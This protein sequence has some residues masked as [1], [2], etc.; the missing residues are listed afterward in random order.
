MSYLQELHEAHKARLARM[1]GKP[2]KP[3]RQVMHDRAVQ[4]TPDIASP[5]P[6]PIPHFRP[7]RQA[8][9]PIPESVQRSFII[10]RKIARVTAAAFGVQ[11]DEILAHDRRSH[12]CLARQVAVF[13][14]RKHTTISWNKIGILFGGYDTSSLRHSRSKV[15]LMVATDEKTMAIVAGI[16]R[17]LASAL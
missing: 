8:W 9:A 3:E 16:E 15:R 6:D 11:L 2:R 1:G 10:A 5:T 12:I 13:L 7:H 14:V 17:D 4:P